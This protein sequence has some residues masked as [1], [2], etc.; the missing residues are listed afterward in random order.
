MLGCCKIKESWGAGNAFVS[1]LL[2]VVNGEKMRHARAMVI[3][4]GEE[5]DDIPCSHCHRFRWM[6]THDQWLSPSRVSTLR[7]MMR[8]RRFLTPGNRYYTLLNRAAL[9]FLD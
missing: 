9:R 1:G 3:G 4:R 8:A 6:K 2:A 5:R 7:L